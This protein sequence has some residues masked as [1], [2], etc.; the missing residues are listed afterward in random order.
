MSTTTVGIAS[1]Q[2]VTL[3]LGRRYLVRYQGGPAHEVVIAGRRRNGDL[4]IAHPDTDEDAFVK[5]RSI[6]SIDAIPESIDEVETEAGQAALEAAHQAAVAARNGTRPKLTKRGA[7]TIAK[8]AAGDVDEATLERAV[9]LADSL[10]AELGHDPDAVAAAVVEAIPELAPKPS[11]ETLATGVGSPATKLELDEAGEV[12]IP[13]VESKKKPRRKLPLPRT[14]EE[15]VGHPIVVD[16]TKYRIR[17]VTVGDPRGVVVHAKTSFGGQEVD[18]LVESFDPVP[19]VY[20]GLAIEV[21]KPI[22]TV[23]VVDR[24]KSKG[25]PYAERNQVWR[26]KVCGKRTRAESC[27]GRSAETSHVVEYAPAGKRRESRS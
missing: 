22:M 5:A 25:R 9:A 14:I 27:N 20:R 23:S 10:A 24:P 2:R 3:T 18:A 16:G 21:A 26:C 19:A 11:R 7:A 4:L 15:L 17:S 12:R 1:G 8:A 13:Y 6:A